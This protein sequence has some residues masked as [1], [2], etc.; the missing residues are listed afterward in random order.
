MLSIDLERRAKSVENK[1][2]LALKCLW[3][4]R[5]QGGF[6]WRCFSTVALHRFG[7]LLLET[8]PSRGSLGFP[9]LVDFMIQVGGMIVEMAP[10]F[11][12]L[13]GEGREPHSHSL[14]LFLL[15]DG[16]H[17]TRRRR[18]NVIALTP[19]WQQGINRPWSYS[20]GTIVRLPRW[21]TATG[22][23]DSKRALLELFLELLNK[24]KGLF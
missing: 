1:E 7:D 23:L 16:S 12:G 5:P 20:P 2:K 15:F 9:F 22:F 11:S 3:L 8:S 18:R 14:V 17:V 19:Q 24:C 4:L 10:F 21:A 13:G 6:R